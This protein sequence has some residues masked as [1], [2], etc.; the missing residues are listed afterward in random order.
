MPWHAPVVV[1]RR[2]SEHMLC[3][4]YERVFEAV[5][6]AIRWYFC[7]DGNPWWIAKEVCDIL[8]IKQVAYAV[9][10]LDYDEK[11]KWIESTSG[12]RRHVWIVNEPGLY[13]LIGKSKKHVA[14][15]FQR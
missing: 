5:H 7:G 3:A 10:T 6:K 12:Q 9:N 8:G 11:L 14:R 1:D 15:M 2:V 4:K 13:R